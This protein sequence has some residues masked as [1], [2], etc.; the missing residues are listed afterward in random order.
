MR[1]LRGEARALAQQAELIARGL[2]RGPRAI[3]GERVAVF[4]H[5]FL[6]A[7]PVFD[8]LRA[9]VGDR[10]GVATLDFTYGP[11]LAFDEI[12]R[13]FDRYLREHVP[14]GVRISLVGHSL[15]GLVARWWVQEL[16]GAAD[17]DR[18]V[19]M[20]TPHAGTRSARFGFG[21]LARALVPESEV[22]A[23]LAAGRHRASGIP[24]TT[25][26]AGRDRMVT[27]PASAAQLDDATVIWFDELGHNAMLYDARVHDAVCRLLGLRDR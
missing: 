1:D 2:W 16:G 7:G 17:V 20:A 22:I 26:V 13:R 14:P 10:C 6:A 9:H 19:T 21:P 8:P 15:G 23:R 24:H 5:G 3:Q 12:A 4:V 27:P 11:F 18:I 25:I